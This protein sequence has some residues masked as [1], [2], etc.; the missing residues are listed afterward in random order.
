MGEMLLIYIIFLYGI[1]TFSW[2]LFFSLLHICSARIYQTF[3]FN[4]YFC[5]TIWCPQNKKGC[6]NTPGNRH[7]AFCLVCTRNLGA[8][9]CVC[10]LSFLAHRMGHRSWWPKC[11]LSDLLIWKQYS[12]SD[13]HMASLSDFSST[14]IQENVSW[15][16]QE[17][18]GLPCPTP[19][20]A[21]FMAE[22]H[23]C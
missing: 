5:R 9:F 14:D 1:W 6:E 8:V 3:H 11:P 22:L 17:G 21:E 18:H 23:Q 13:T 16:M 20:P 15:E 2:K 4:T 10:A 12:S 19:S 7:R